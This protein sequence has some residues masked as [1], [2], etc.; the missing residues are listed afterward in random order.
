M[1]DKLR[2]LVS[3]CL[4]GVACR[5]DGKSVFCE[6]V[7]RLMDACE[8][9]PV[10]P[11]ILGGMTTPRPPSERQGERVVNNLGQDVTAAFLRGADQALHLARLFGVKYAVLKQRSPSCGSEMIYDG[12]FSGG[13]IP[14]KGVTAEAFEREGIRIFDEDHIC[15]LIDIL[16]D[17]HND[18]L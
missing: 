3:Q 11:E 6:S 9:I 12:T 16:E 17:E 15:E 18:T 8:V 14:G 5:Y 2:V 4:L 1:K 13:K 10:C 7:R